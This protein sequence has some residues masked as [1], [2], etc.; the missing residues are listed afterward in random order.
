MSV[1]R[2]TARLLPPGLVVDA[3]TVGP[4][5]LIIAAHA[6][7]Q[8]S[9]CPECGRLSRRVHSCSVPDDHIDPRRRALFVARSILSEVRNGGRGC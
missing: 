9:Q 2:K 6:L 4:D 7:G 5:E 1:S 8:G 3:V